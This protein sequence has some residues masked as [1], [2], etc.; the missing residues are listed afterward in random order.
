M[1]IRA[2]FARTAAA[3]ALATSGIAGAVATAQPAAADPVIAIDWNLEA[4]VTIAKLGISQSVTGGE[5][6]GGADLGNGTIN[7]NLVLPSSSINVNILGIN[8]ADVGF[9]V[10]PIGATSGTFDLASSTVSITSSFDIKIPFLRPLGLQR[11]NLVGNR[12]QTAEPI[13][14]TMSGPIDLANPSS[15]TGEFT[16]PK[17]KNCGLLTFAINLLIPGG[18]NTFSATASPKA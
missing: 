4:N 14:L 8:L 9:A 16:I 17:F 18:G 7:G 10:T 12:C 11:I 15:F 1:S 3:L 2:K 6:V 13:T 5:F